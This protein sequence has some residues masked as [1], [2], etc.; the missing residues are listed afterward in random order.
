MK[1]LMILAAVAAVSVGAYAN[2]CSGTTGAASE[3]ALYNVKFT[4]K[5]LLGKD[6][7]SKDVCNGTS[8]TVA[9]LD[10]GTRTFE[11]ILWDCEVG[12]SFFDNNP[13]FVMW[14]KK[15]SI[16]VTTKLTYTASNTTYSADSAAFDFVDRYS[17]KATKVEAYWPAIDLSWD[18]G[19]GFTG[20]GAFYA[21][22][23]GTYDAKTQ[24][25]KSISGNAVGYLTPT[26]GKCGDPML[27]DLCTEFDNWADDG[28]AAT[29]VAASGTWSVK[30]NASL[31]KGSKTLAQIVPSYARE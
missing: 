2:L 21:A 13:N 26:S 24:L 8:T 11:G 6:V 30:Y 23:F 22:G 18:N 19:N 25:V 17:K 5:T 4:M 28:T 12:C 7:S 14:E 15:Y 27:C 10:N 20:T 9:Y 3:C 29:K 31:S 1:K 16:G